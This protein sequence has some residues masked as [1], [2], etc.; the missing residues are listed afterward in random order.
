[1]SRNLFLCCDTLRPSARWLDAFP[2]GIGSGHEALV[3]AARPGDVIWVPSAHAH[4][5]ELLVRLGGALPESPLVVLSM[6]PS[7]D[8]AV[9]A[10]DRG[11]RGYCHAL[12]VT[13]LLREV[14]LVVRHG[15][16]WIG[17]ELMTRVIGAA[18]RALPPPADHA[19]LHGLSARET[20]VAQE[21][22]AGSSNREIAARLGITER[23]VKAH[24]GAVFEKLG[25]RDRLQLVL[26]L[27]RGSSQIR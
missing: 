24:L 21:A 20:E 10:L 2:E 12:A 3:G 14:A 27:A 11:A 25:V 5:D 1:M 19:R 8:E 17:A 7:S 6:T 15:G 16:L 26:R 18:R 9:V 23:T 4:W 22:A 13:T